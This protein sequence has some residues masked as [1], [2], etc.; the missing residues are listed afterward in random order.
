MD[1]KKIIIG[2]L[3]LKRL[4]RSFAIFYVG[5]CIFAFFYAEKLIF[6]YNQSSYNN[7]ITG[8]KIFKS[9]DDTDIASRFWKAENEKYLILYFH[10]NYLDLGD[11][12]EVANIFNAQGYSIL[13]MDYRGYGLSQGN[14]TEKNSY[15]DSQTIYD[16]A[17][18]SG[19]QA[20]NLI[21]LG[22]SV[23]SGIAT[24]LAL[25]NKAKALILISPFASAFRVMTKIPLLPFDRFNN[26]AKISKIDEPLFIIHGQQDKIIPAW[27]SQ[28]LYEKHKGKKLRHVIPQAGHND[29]YSFKFEDLFASLES[30][31]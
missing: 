8:L 6:P 24:E 2:D 27:H 9:K 16:E 4:F 25:K 29:I 19:Y 30:F 14:A 13:A 31:L 20:D 3:T 7:Q 15:E 12:D 1:W 23:G 11:L 18:K 10:G 21:I 17:I 26:Q 5:I 28:N 22:R